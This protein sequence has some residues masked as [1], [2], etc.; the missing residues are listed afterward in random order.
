MSFVVCWFTNLTVKSTFY[1]SGASS[2]GV[3]GLASAH[4]P[5]PLLTEWMTLDGS[6]ISPGLL[7]SVVRRDD[8]RTFSAAVRC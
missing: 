8:H 6:R 3:K 7:S 5:A 4:N 1:L 2:A